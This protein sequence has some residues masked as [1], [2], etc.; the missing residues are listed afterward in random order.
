[1]N[2]R[3]IINIKS[4]FMVKY[5]KKN[6]ISIA[7]VR[8]ALITT[9]YG[10]AYAIEPVNLNEGWGTNYKGLA[11]LHTLQPAFSTSTGFNLSALNQSGM[12][13]GLLAAFHILTINK[14][15]FS[16]GK[17]AIGLAHRPGHAA[18]PARFSYK[19]SNV[20]GF[21]LQVG[22]FDLQFPI[23]SLIN[24]SPQFHA[25]ANYK[26][27]FEDG[28]AL[29]WASFLWQDQDLSMQDGSL[30]SS[31]STGWNVG[32]DLT[33]GGFNVAGSYYDGEAL[34]TNLFNL[35][36]TENICSTSYCIESENDGY[37][38]QGAYTFNGTTKIGVSW[39]ES[40]ETLYG[41]ADKSTNELWTVGVYHDVTSWLKVMAE[42][43]N[44]D[45]EA[46]VFGPNQHD[47]IAIGGFLVW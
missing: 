3:A 43:G 47:V 20:S 36:S 44:A 2:Y 19:T 7:I 11:D 34:A 29:I 26:S 27:E 13:G 40:K 39:G 25:E 6:S 28:N 23:G 37:V 31:E 10:S 8:I 38:L 9:L 33:V 14:P 12:K 15:E 5:L 16:T 45:S 22:I 32:L 24:S 41:G 4:F 42:Y 18:L 21:G 46:A 17:S 35:G 1:L 30:D